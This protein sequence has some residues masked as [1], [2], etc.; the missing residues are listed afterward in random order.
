VIEYVHRKEDEHWGFRNWTL[1]LLVAPSRL[2]AQQHDEK[3]APGEV[4]SRLL[5]DLH[6]LAW[7]NDEQKELLETVKASPQEYQDAIQDAMALPTDVE[8]LT[9]DEKFHRI[10]NAL[11]L[12]RIVGGNEMRAVVRPFFTETSDALAHLRV[13][14]P[15]P[16]RKVL[17]RVSGLR[18][19][20]LETMG[21]WGDPSAIDVCLAQVERED[22]ATRIVFL[23]YFLRVGRGNTKL[24][25]QLS[26]MLDSEA[27]PLSREPLARKVLTEISKPTSPQSVSKDIPASQ[28]MKREPE[29]VERDAPFRSLL[30]GRT[31][32]PV[33]R[34]CGE[35]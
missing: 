7:P 20:A 2:Q 17:E 24:K 22:A 5:S 27:S 11:A 35:E 30:S 9:D 26:T 28:P 16:D 8:C 15:A 21:L 14:Q 13:E 29:R 4:V 19:I 1:S 12:A 33:L 18:R 6:G 3:L 23:R 31:A 32:L 34:G 25:S 10:A